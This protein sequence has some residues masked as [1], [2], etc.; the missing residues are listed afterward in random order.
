[1]TMKILKVINSA[2][3]ALP[4]RI[5]SVNHSVIYLGINTIKNLSLSVAAAGILPNVSS[6]GFN[7][8]HYLIHS[9]STA[10][11]ARQLCTIFGGEDA[12]PGDCYVA[13]LLHDFGKVIFAQFMATEFRNALMMS[14][15]NN[16]PLYQAERNLIGVDHGYAGAMLTAR[17]KFPEPLVQ[18][19]RDHHVEKAERTAMLD[20][21]R[22][23]D[24]ICRSIGMEDELE[25][26]EDQLPAAPERFGDRM[27]PVLARLG[28]LKKMI[29]EARAFAIAE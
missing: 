4:Q 3:Y 20:C 9:L 28:N 1:M 24:Q 15:N 17:W 21:L 25:V 29:D 22:V 16:M 12:D 11:V 18:C 23:A 7:T 6:E 2:Y 27:G 19:I 13:G 14:E 26:W 10:S 8:Q 5:T